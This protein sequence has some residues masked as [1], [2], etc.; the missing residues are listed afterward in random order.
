MNFTNPGAISHNEVSSTGTAAAGQPAWV[1]HSRTPTAAVVCVVGG[2]D[3]LAAGDGWYMHVCTRSGQGV[4]L[5]LL[6]T[7]PSPACCRS[8]SCTRSTSTPTSPGPTSRW[9]S[10][11]RSSWRH[12][13]T[14]CWTRNGCAPASQPHQHTHGLPGVCRMC[15]CGVH[16]VLL[17]GR[18]SATAPC[19][20]FVC[21]FG[22][23]TCF[24]FAAC[25]VQFESEFPQMLPIRESLIKYVFEPNA[26]KVSRRHARLPCRHSRCLASTPLQ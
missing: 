6:C 12:A 17:R 9:R 8:C 7:N 3:R 1:E 15:D 4:V 11:P 14:T 19:T 18:L 26:A 16:D 13:A 2:G 20:P 24:S 22:W 25:A 23:L 21:C 5:L 10:R